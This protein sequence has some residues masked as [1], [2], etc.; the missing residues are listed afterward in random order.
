ME[1]LEA[2]PPQ[3]RMVRKK[4]SWERA[5]IRVSS[6]RFCVQY[7]TRG[8]KNPQSFNFSPQKI[9]FRVIKNC[10]SPPLQSANPLRGYYSHQEYQANFPKSSNEALPKSITLVYGEEGEYI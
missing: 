4:G 1:R 8:E 9:L 6:L 3:E 10:Q 2:P 7:P 5:P